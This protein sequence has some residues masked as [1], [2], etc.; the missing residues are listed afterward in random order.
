MYEWAKD[1]GTSTFDKTRLN[2]LATTGRLVKVAC[3]SVDSSV[4]EGPSADGGLDEG[5]VVD[6]L[7]APELN[8]SDIAA[9]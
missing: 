8:V 9:L 1:P 2:A 4:P 5:P 7:G 3:T 6:A